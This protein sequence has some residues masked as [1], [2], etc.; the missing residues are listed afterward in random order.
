MN[1]LLRDLFG[2][3]FWA[4]V[5]LW[6]AIGAHAPAREDKVIRERLHHIHLVQRVLGR[7]RLVLEGAARG[8]LVSLK[9]SLSR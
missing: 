4:D 8:V 5:T 9:R 1:P 2:H 6:T 7:D 3:Q